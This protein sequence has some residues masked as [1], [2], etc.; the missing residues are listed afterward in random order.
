MDAPLE[1]ARLSG[2]DLTMADLFDA[3]ADG[4]D[5][6]ETRL[7]STGFEGAQLRGAGFRGANVLATF[8]EADLRD[9]D[10]RGATFLGTVLGFADL[11]GAILEPSAIAGRPGKPAIFRR[12]TT[13]P[14]G[15]R[16]SAAGESCAGHL[17]G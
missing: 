13:C 14:D 8:T 16:T 6:R 12:K 3:V 5:F 9:A 1:G 4:A 7:R 15:H 2:V 10:F 17:S 11:R